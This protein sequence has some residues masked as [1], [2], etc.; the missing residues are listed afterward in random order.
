MVTGSMV[1]GW[2]PNGAGVG[3][4]V[5]LPAPVAPSREGAP[6]GW[7]PRPSA[8]SRLHDCRGQRDI[9]ARLSP[10]GAAL[11]PAHGTAARLLL[12]LPPSSCSSSSSSRGRRGRDP[13]HSCCSWATAAAET[14]GCEPRSPGLGSERDSPGPAAPRRPSA[15]PAG[16]AASGSRAARSAPPPAPPL[17][18]ELSRVPA[19]RAPASGVF[20]PAGPTSCAS[21][22]GCTGAGR[23][24]E[25]AR[26]GYKVPAP[27]CALG[28]KGGAG[29]DTQRNSWEGAGPPGQPTP[30][31]FPLSAGLRTLGV[32][33]NGLSF[34]G[35]GL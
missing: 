31:T 10:G 30:V 13:G 9:P 15:P 3:G 27:A 12:Q 23:S 8:P 19:P 2:A 1:D 33:R 29:P 28:I 20:P 14:R 24:A 7:S 17:G 4:E 6:R 16:T 35:G 32:A 34:S 21:L 25:R 22:A 5:L 11:S 18:C 26:S